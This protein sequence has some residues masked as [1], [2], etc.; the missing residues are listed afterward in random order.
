M[1]DGGARPSANPHA[2]DAGGAEASAARR[3]SQRLRSG[4]VH[5]E[6]C[7]AVGRGM[8]GHG[9]LGGGLHSQH[10]SRS[11]HSTGGGASS[12]SAGGPPRPASGGSGPGSVGARP[13]S[14][15]VRAA[16]LD[17][18]PHSG[19]SGASETLPSQG[20]L[21]AGQSQLCH[22]FS[23][24]ASH[25]ADHAA[26]LRLGSSR[27]GE[28]P[29][30]A[31]ARGVAKGAAGAGAPTAVGCPGCMCGSAPPT[32]AA[33]DS[34]AL[35]LHM[36]GLATRATQL[37]RPGV[38]GAQGQG[39]ALAAALAAQ[40]QLQLLQGLPHAAGSGPELKAGMAACKLGQMEPGSKA[41]AWAAGSAGAGGMGGMAAAAEAA[42]WQ[43]AAQHRAAGEVAAL[44]G[45]LAWPPLDP[46]AS[47]FLGLPKRDSLAVALEEAAA[48]AWGTGREDSPRQR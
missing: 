9:E 18:A 14:A 29:A 15:A 11:T 32:A 28:A 24:A 39:P 27:Q 12:S 38:A 40:R 34:Q 6:L 3:S 44:A 26:L 37:L 35:A 45:M 2:S 30:S 42:A 10:H 1:V 8:A 41:G 22:A 48:N 33:L 23:H 17:C 16:V 46:Q 47:T 21:L 4:A 7:T 19:G 20:A 43:Q 36:G 25:M 31:L 5:D 13:P